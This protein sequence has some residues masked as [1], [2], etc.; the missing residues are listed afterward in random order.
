[1]LLVM[2]MALKLDVTCRIGDTLKN[3]HCSVSMSN[4]SPT[5]YPQKQEQIKT[6]QQE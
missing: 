4:V 3:S 5:P 6:K 1:M 2:E